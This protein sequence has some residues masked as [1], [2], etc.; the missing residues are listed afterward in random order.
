MIKKRWL[1]HL[2]AGLCLL[3]A[4]PAFAQEKYFIRV[5]DY[6]NSL[7]PG[8]AIDSV[9]NLCKLN[10]TY[11]AY[12]TGEHT[13]PGTLPR[14]GI[15]VQCFMENPNSTFK[16]F[17]MDVYCPKGFSHRSMVGIENG[18]EEGCYSQMA[19]TEARQLARLGMMTAPQECCTPIS[20]PPNG[21]MCP[22]I[23]PKAS[24][25]GRVACSQNEPRQN[26]QPCG[27]GGTADPQANAIV[28][29]GVFEHETFHKNDP[30]LF[31]QTG[32]PDK[33]YVGGGYIDAYLSEVNAS[34]VELTYLENNIKTCCTP[35]CQSEIKNRHVQMKG[36]C[37]KFANDYYL[38][39][40]IDISDRCSRSISE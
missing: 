7:N 14:V 21:D 13:Y 28:K 2:L 35:L 37:L 25:G 11:G 36:Y 17:G 19:C 39:T 38:L 1:K 26:W 23:P 33:G 31:C 3:M 20:I 32:G 22:S 10:P 18:L 29:N 12:A 27:W 16:S 4:I 5:S 9:S 30:A 24:S 40:H 15:Y 34:V 8:A 6:M